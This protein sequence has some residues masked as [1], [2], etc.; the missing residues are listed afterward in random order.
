MEKFLE[1]LKEAEKKIR[2][3][4]HMIYVTFPLIKD[5]RILLLLISELKKAIANCINAI[6]QYDYL[7]KRISLYEDVKIN[8]ETFKSKSSKRFNITNQEI[9]LIIKLFELEQNHKK[10]S[11]EFA[12]DNKIVILSE[13][14]RQRIITLE[15]IK[16]FLQL[17]KDVLKKTKNIIL[18]KI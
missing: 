16:Q 6:L 3:A 10:S 11:M 8:F 17:S 2:M 12:K 18:G 7:Y 14:M 15:E 5:K 4:D 13:D 9:A 1:S